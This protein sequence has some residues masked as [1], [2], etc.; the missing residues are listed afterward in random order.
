MDLLEILFGNFAFIFVLLWILGS[1]FGQG[2][3]NGR[4][5]Q[6]P[7]RPQPVEARPTPPATIDPQPMET[8]PVP[9]DPIK[10]EPDP[11]QKEP[12]FDEKELQPELLSKPLEQIKPLQDEMPSE[13]G[14]TRHIKEVEPIPLPLYAKQ[15]KQDRLPP[16]GQFRSQ[17][18]QGVIWSEILGLPRS[19]QPLARTR[20]FN[21]RNR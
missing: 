19:K 14:L 7:K 8:E 12:P 6:R 17:V 5:Q 10:T 11:L 20:M 4:T 2:K 9:L 16:L 15:T 3:K 13:R 1:I 18:V 21:Q